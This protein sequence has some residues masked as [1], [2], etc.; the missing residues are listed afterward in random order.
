MKSK[1]FRGL[2]AG[3]LAL[4]M[5]PAAQAAVRPGDTGDAVR[6]LQQALSA[7]GFSIAVDGKYG[8]ATA[9]A[10]LAFQRARS[11][12]ADGIAGSQTLGALSGAIPAAPLAPT[13]LPQV[14]AA[15]PVQTAGRYE[16][17]STGDGVVQLQV[18]LA[19]LGFDAGRTDGIFDENTRQAV[20]RFQ[21]QQGLKADGIAGRA[22][23]GSLQARETVQYPQGES[24]PAAAP[25]TGSVQGA[26]TVRTA[27][28]GSLRFRATAGTKGNNVLGSIPNG[29]QVELL[30]QQE[31][32]TAIRY[33]GQS[34]FVMSQ[35]LLIG[36]STGSPQSPANPS[37][38]Q[39]PAPTVPDV[40]PQ[41]AKGK[42]TV[43]SSNGKAV[44]VRTSPENKG[45]QNYLTQVRNGETLEVLSSGATWSQ[46]RYRGQSCYI[47]T[48]FLRFT[49]LGP[50]P[51]AEPTAAPTQDPNAPLNEEEQIRFSRILRSGTEGADVSALQVKLE[52]LRYSVSV[53]G[54]YDAATSAAVRSFQSLNGLTVDGVAGGR[55]IQALFSGAARPSDSAPLTFSTLRMGATD[56]SGTAVT[57]L[58]TALKGLGFSL[59]VDGSYGAKTHDA[60]VGFQLRNGL[61][62]S[63]TA[64]ALTQN[65]LY[66]GSAKGADAPV[67]DVEPGTA[68]GPDGSTVKL[69]DWYT[70]VKPQIRSGQTATIYHP[71][72]GITFDL[73][74]YSLGRHA[75]SEPKTLKDTQLMNKAFGE[76]SWD[77]RSVYVKM[78][79]GEWTLA[80]MHNYP[81]LSGSIADNGFG[82]HLCVHFKRD[83]E[84]T[85][86]ADP[87]YGV[88]NQN[89]I[90]ATWAKMTGV[91]VH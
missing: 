29:R 85:K 59:T 4:A 37:A 36:G 41:G 78:P 19:A 11:L 18:R 82:G 16:L 43:V 12:K 58:Q 7:Q 81:H 22:T 72:S 44:N 62:V 26:A 27:N 60:V 34:G 10:V 21:R 2:L 79:N 63:G 30:G 42:A 28:G 71:D 74:Y 8:Q 64:D 39:V 87:N 32:W 17:G 88:Q 23:L 69:L 86:K 1:L 89:A 35:F 3:L 76:T 49:E 52:G 54:R 65:M 68:P 46:V 40:L 51:A 20:L 90:R 45:N 9:A 70:E 73:Q 66:S 15:A 14:P 84:E 25:A 77:T 61:T 80:T 24:A 91:Q 50:A 13:S 31:E 38:P 55:T 48:S 83:M 5:M 67:P 56:G 57:M 33:N 53:N 75:D 47:M 6:A